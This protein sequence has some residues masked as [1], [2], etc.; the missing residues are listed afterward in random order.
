MR[1]KSLSLFLFLLGLTLI[2]TPRYSFADSGESAF[3]IY[4]KIAGRVVDASDGQPLPGVN[5]YI[6]GTT[7]G[8]STD[9]NGDYIILRVRPGT[10]TVK[11][12]FIGFAGQTVQGVKVEVD[13]TTRVDFTMA[14]EIFE[15]EEVVITA[16]RGIVQMDRT[17]TTAFVDS[18]Q[19]KALPVTTIGD[20]I[21]LQAGVVDGRFRGGRSGEVAYL[22]NGVPINNAFNNQAAF[23]VEQN[24]VSSLQ[25]ISGVFNAEYG[26]AQSGIVNIV[27]KD[28]PSEWSANVLSYIG[29]IASTREAE[30]L[31]RNTGPGLQ[32]AAS[33]FSSEMVSYADASDLR[34]LTDIQASIGGPIKKDRLGFQM[35]GRYLSNNGHLLGRDLFAPSDS[36]TGLNASSNPEDWNVQSTGSGD[37]VNMT[38]NERLSLN[39]TVTANL[40]GTTRLEYNLFLQDGQFSNYSHSGKYVPDGR[41]TGYFG[42]QTHILS[43]R[44]TVGQ[45]SFGSVSYSY[46]RDKYD[47]YLLDCKEVDELGNLDCKGNDQYQW[48]QKSSLSGQNAFAVGGN[49]LFTVDE[50]TE[51]HTILADFSSQ[52]D[53]VHLI[54]G[55]VMTRLHGLDN[56]TYGIERSARTNNLPRISPDVFSDNSLNAHPKEFSAYIQDKME[57]KGLI[58]NAGLRFDYF[59]P[60]YLIPNDWAQ[61]ES[62]EVVNPDNPT[63]LISN[64]KEAAAQTQFSPRLGV[65]FPISATGVMRFS[66]G[67]F[68]QTPALNLLYTN[69]E[70]EVNPTSSSNQFGNPALS[71]ERTLSFEVGLQQGL[72]EDIG[73]ELTI[74]SKDVRNLTGQQV[75]RT[76]QGDFAIRWINRDYGTIRGMTFSL[77]DRPGGLLSWTLDYTLQFAEGTSSD[78]GEAFGRQQSG[79]EEI[80]SLVRLNWDR[81]HVLNNTITLNPVENFS[82]TLVNYLRSGEPY[83]TTRNFVRST[84]TNNADRPMQFWS[85]LR[86]YYRPPFVK[87]DIQ[88]FLQIQNLFDNEVKY[89]VYASTGRVDED[90]QKELFRRTGAQ[91]GGLNSL[92]EYYSHPEWISAPRKISLGLNLRF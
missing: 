88:L 91:V 59:D 44:Y 53:N 72:T 71:P 3:D 81:R 13:Q 12:T 54:K 56:R 84:L 86:A 43:L 11:A 23:E 89:N 77:F 85:D 83:T 24:M 18:E 14:E 52:I 17:T 50:L 66:A 27:T 62:E 76:P 51:T 38:E 42:S 55:G 5:V 4:G 30:F 19:L 58:V 34:N 16:E 25:V 69:P 8:S 61:A 70:Y 36:S 10:Y 46:L 40:G 75:L 47:S 90:L 32:L 31:Q 28:V 63:E 65:A 6:D 29:S 7:L 68:F 2:S 64:R 1:D 45:R 9:A 60:D 73:L 20:A 92:D 79:L 26:Q 21:N 87:R 82:F 74:F 22:V 80:L 39:T 37:F 67:M 41:N 48:P 49:D 33:D 15:G 57:F 78:P 35:T